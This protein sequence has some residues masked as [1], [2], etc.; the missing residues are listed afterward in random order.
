MKLI[1]LRQLVQSTNTAIIVLTV[2]YARFDK[3]RISIQ[4]R[5]VMGF[6]VM[7]MDISKRTGYLVEVET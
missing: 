1:A 2:V 4:S 5:S 3:F 6:L 7:G